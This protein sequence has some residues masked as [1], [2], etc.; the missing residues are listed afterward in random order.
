MTWDTPATVEGFVRSAPNPM[1][2]QYAAQLRR[3]DRPTV[4]LDIGCGAGRNAVPLANAGFHVLGTDL[5]W[6]MLAAAA[7]R[8]RGGR[9][10]VVQASMDYVPVR[11]RCSDLII[12]HGIWNLARSGAEFRR[13][14]GEAARAAVPGASLFVFTFSRRTVP[15][16][17]RPVAG[18]TFVYTEFANAP[19]IFLTREQLAEELAAHGFTADPALPLRELNVPPPGQVRQGGP[20]VIFEAGF[21]FN[22][23]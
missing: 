22:G 7:G 14:V 15:P 9:V 4:V 2:L 19:Q 12:A 5:S 13:A 20:P 6:P 21:R 17:A 11:D 16:E 1:L 23:V 10:Q 3:Q 18:E 8:D